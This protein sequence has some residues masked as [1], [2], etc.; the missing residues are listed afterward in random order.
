MFRKTT[1]RY[2]ARFF[3]GERAGVF[4]RVDGEPVL[5][6]ELSDGGEPDSDGAVTEAG[7]LGED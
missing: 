2:R 6:P 3:D 4:G 1:A 5:L 7:G